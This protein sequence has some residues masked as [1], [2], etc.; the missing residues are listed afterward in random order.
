MEVTVFEYID[1]I[2]TIA[3]IN[4]E[5]MTVMAIEYLITPLKCQKEC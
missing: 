1:I 3:D 4:T 5:E 2:N